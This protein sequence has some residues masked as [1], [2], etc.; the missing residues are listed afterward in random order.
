MT[1]LGVA[2]VLVLEDNEE[3]YVTID[4][5]CQ[6]S[7]HAIRLQ[8]FTRAE[9]LIEQITHETLDY[10]AVAL[11]DLRMPGGG[12]IE[13]LK[14]LKSNTRLSSVPCVV[15]STSTN[16]IEIESC[17][18]AGANVFHE[19]LVETSKMID[20]LK[21]ILDYWLDAAHLAPPSRN[22]ARVE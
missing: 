10:P 18:R 7:E 1:R 22:E 5:A 21:S 20:R 4:I 8:R 2:R 11:L 3:D 12:G 14:A 13:V 6:E 19:K 17:Y 9:P 16:P 15:L